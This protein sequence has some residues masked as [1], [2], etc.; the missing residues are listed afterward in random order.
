MR[1]VLSQPAF[2]RVWEA[3]RKEDVRPSCASTDRPY[4]ALAKGKSPEAVV[5]AEALRAE[6]QHA[7]EHCVGGHIADFH[8]FV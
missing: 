1:P 6:E 3:I 2:M 5:F 4:W 8:K 7:L